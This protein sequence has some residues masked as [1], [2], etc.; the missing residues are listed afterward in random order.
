M[1]LTSPIWFCKLV[2][3]ETFTPS[4]RLM[5]GATLV[6]RRSLPAEPTETVFAWLAT[7]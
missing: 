2:S 7:E 6:K 3:C 5:P 1:R 4:V